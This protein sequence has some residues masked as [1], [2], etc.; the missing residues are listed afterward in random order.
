MSPSMSFW[1]TRKGRGWKIYCGIIV[2]ILYLT[3]I[4]LNIIFDV[5]KC[6]WFK[7]TPKES[8]LN[9]VL[10]IIIYLIWTYDFGLYYPNST[11]FKLIGYLDVDCVGKKL[12]INLPVAAIRSLAHH[13]PWHYK[14][15]M[16]ITLNTVKSKY[17]STGSF[18]TQLH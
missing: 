4:I 8:H 16:P 2:Y 5:C 10:R 18:G 1:W 15:Y 17:L 9:M 13:Y 7:Y 12:I 6:A 11:H 14:K 3:E